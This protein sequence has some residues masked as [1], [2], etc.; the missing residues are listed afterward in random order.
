MYPIGKV[1]PGTTQT[2]T[3]QESRA[4][5]DA[6]GDS[7]DDYTGPDA[8]CHATAKTSFMIEP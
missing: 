5:A 3:L 1:Y 6:T 2:I 7:A 8:I 4:Y